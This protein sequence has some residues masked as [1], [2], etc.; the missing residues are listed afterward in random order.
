[1]L[2]NKCGNEYPD[3]LGYCP[4]CNKTQEQTAAINYGQPMPVQPGFQQPMPAQPGFQQPMPA[5]PGFQQPMPVPVKK[6]SNLP[7][8]IVAIVVIAAIIAGAIFLPGL[9]NKEE[10]PQ[11]EE[12]G[13]V[14]PEPPV[15]I[16][17]I[18]GISFESVMNME[19]SMDIEYDE[20]GLPVK[21]LMNADGETTE[22]KVV[23]DKETLTYTEETYENGV[24]V[25]SEKFECDE[26]WNDKKSTTYVDGVETS[27]TLYEYNDAGKCIKKTVYEGSVETESTVYEYDANNNL[28]KEA[29]YKNGVAVDTVACVYD[30]NGHITKKTHEYEDG[31]YSEHIYSYDAN[32]L[33]NKVV[34]YEN[35]TQAGYDEIS[36]NEKGELISRDTY[37]MGM[38]VITTNLEYETI[39]V[40]SAFVGMIEEINSSFLQEAVFF[41]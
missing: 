14:A 13:Q 23:Y 11:G 36:Y 27:Y 31:V 22:V 8:I 5:Q 7:V 25:N 29:V 15:E 9:L 20:N 12:Q 28:T 2:C 39:S 10:K 37:M 34:Y 19:M 16:N 40:D 1:M 3:N 33:C 4:Y 38:K 32:G 17:T 35:G 26:K 6:K 18:T 41:S 21:V 24:L 30:A